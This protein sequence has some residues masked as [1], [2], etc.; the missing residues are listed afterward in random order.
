[1][2][3]PLRDFG[4]SRVVFFDKRPLVS[5]NVVLR[6]APQAPCPIL[7]FFL[8][9]FVTETRFAFSTIPYEAS[10]EEISK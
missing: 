8:F 9:Y 1:M 5:C 4:T 10:I 2:Q 7:L 6:K 3:D